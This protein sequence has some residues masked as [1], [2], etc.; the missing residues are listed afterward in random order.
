MT[1]RLLGTCMYTL[2]LSSICDFHKRFDHHLDISQ[3]SPGK[4]SPIF[5]HISYFYSTFHDF[6][7]QR[8]VSSPQQ[9]LVFILHLA[10]ARQPCQKWLPYISWGR[11]R[12]GLPLSFSSRRISQWEQS[13]TENRSWWKTQCVLNARPI[14]MPHIC[15]WW[16]VYSVGWTVKEQEREGE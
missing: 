2:R 8:E 5:I 14:L 7:V 4:S 16:G 11:E 13:A 10:D 1:T 9:P 6:K 3:E 15:M 12:E